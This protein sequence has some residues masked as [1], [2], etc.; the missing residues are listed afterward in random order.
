MARDGFALIATVW[1]LV[2]LSAAS[3][4][5]ALEARSRRVMAM[6]AVESDIATGAA[7]G[8]LAQGKAHLVTRLLAWQREKLESPQNAAF[9][10]LADLNATGAD[11][12]VVGRLHY[13]RTAQDANS[14]LHL[15]RASGAEL[16]RFLLAVNVQPELVRELTAAIL[17]WRGDEDS[18]RLE[19]ERARYAQE[20]RALLP[21][22]RPFASLAELR[23]VRGVTPELCE[24]L[25]GHLTVLG[26]GK[27]NVNTADAPVLLALRGMTAEAV[28]RILQRRA[29]GYPITDLGQLARELSLPARRQLLFNLASLT[30]QTVTTVSEIHITA[31]AR[32]DG[33]PIHARVEALF[34]RTGTE[35]QMVWRRAS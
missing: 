5:L 9:D 7:H 12:E 32:L 2:A 8:A 34:V 15:N 3:M 13:S 33:S 24:V 6:T 4:Q 21:P 23:S 16:Q 18:R 27:I 11:D 25:R 26:S 29:A 10:P 17:V 31:E 22:G 30:G 35:L 1:L 14:R 20:R 28:S 19:S